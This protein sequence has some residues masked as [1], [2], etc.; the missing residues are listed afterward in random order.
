MILNNCTF[1]NNE[2]YLVGNDVLNVDKGQVFLNG[3]QI[4]GSFGV[5]KYKKS[6]SSILTKVLKWGSVAISAVVGIAVGV[7]SQ[8]AVIGMVAGAATAFVLGTIS[9]VIINRYTYDMHYSPIKS[10][11]FIIGTSVTAGIFGGLAGGLIVYGVYGIPLGG[12]K[13]AGSILG[14]I[15]VVV[16]GTTAGKDPHKING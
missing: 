4:N 9:S 3:E 14:V 8:S 16:A 1:E 10:T 11:T 7:A 5:V 15:S 6:I 12:E 2:A 13:I